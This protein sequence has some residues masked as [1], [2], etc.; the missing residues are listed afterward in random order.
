M[1]CVPAK[2]SAK[3]TCTLTS[4]WLRFEDGR[5]DP[6]LWTRRRAARVRNSTLHPGAGPVM[7]G[8]THRAPHGEPPPRPASSYRRGPSR[9][10]VCR[11]PSRARSLS[12]PVTPPS[13]E[14]RLHTAHRPATRTAAE[15]ASESDTTSESGSEPVRAGSRSRRGSHP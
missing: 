6:A 8:G 12:Q 4:G 1:S 7:R 5:G 13:G 10:A 3:C 14:A 9:G 11:P 2:H 15:P